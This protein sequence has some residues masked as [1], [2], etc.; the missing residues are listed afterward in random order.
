M[1]NYSKRENEIYATITGIERDD[2]DYF[3]FDEVRFIK[4][5]DDH[6][7]MFGQF[8]EVREIRQWQNDNFRFEPQLCQVTI[9]SKDWEK[10]KYNRELRKYDG[11]E[12]ITQG[13]NEQFLCRLIK[14]KGLVES[15]K[16]YTG[17]IDLGSIRTTSEIMI[18]DGLDTKG[19]VLSQETRDYLLEQIVILAELPNLHYTQNPPEIKTFTSKQ[20]SN[21]YAPKLTHYE[22]LQER[23]RFLCES[24][25]LDGNTSMQELSL[26]ISNNVEDD[27]DREEVNRLIKLIGLVMLNSY[28][29]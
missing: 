25:G 16:A 12:L 15:N 29:Q 2:N 11:T 5:S 14:E 3:H 7:L 19:N 17:F 27:A 26:Y 23:K 4:K 10:P 24:F 22:V 18:F 1:L 9:H 13:E 28:F 8:V 20:S 6:Y 21:T